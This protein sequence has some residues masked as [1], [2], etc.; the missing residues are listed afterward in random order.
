MIGADS[1]LTID[2]ILSADTMFPNPIFTNYQELA[3]NMQTRQNSFMYLLIKERV[4]NE[5]IIKSLLEQEIAKSVNPDGE[6][7]TLNANFVKSLMDSLNAE[8]ERAIN[9]T[10]NQPI[11]LCSSPIRLIFR[12][13]IERTY[14]QITIMSYNEI[15]NN[16]KAKSVGIIRANM[17]TSSI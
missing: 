10:G 11:I 13:L 2:I 15:T 7:L 6:S 12:K 5:L 8:F 1:G 14:P 17:Q 3:K 9:Q 16:T 4:V